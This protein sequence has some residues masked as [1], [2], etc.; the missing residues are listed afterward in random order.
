[1]RYADLLVLPSRYEGVPNAALEALALGTPVIASDCP[2][3]IRELRDLDDR[4]VLAPMGNA[5][6]LTQAIIGYCKQPQPKQSRELPAEF[7]LCK[8]M[9]EYSR[10]FDAAGSSHECDAS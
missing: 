6:A 1:M 10:L 7:S 8:I 3:G 5:N 4:V 2:G 9:D